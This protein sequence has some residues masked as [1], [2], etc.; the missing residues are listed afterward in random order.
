MSDAEERAHSKRVLV[1]TV[2]GSPLPVM[3][4]HRRDRRVAF[5]QYTT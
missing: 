4:H 5:V 3:V 2:G 1:A